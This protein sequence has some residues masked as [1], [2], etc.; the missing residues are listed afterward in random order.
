MNETIAQ[1]AEQLQIIL[2][3]VLEEADRF[4][5]TLPNRPAGI[6]PQPISL[7]PLPPEGLGATGALQAFRRRFAAAMTGSSGSRYF[8]FVTG[9]ATPAAIAGDWLTSIYDQ[10]AFGSEDSAAPYLEQ[11]AIGWLRQLFGLSAAHQGTFVTGA[12]MANLVGLAIGRQWVGHQQGINIAQAGLI[13]LPALTVFSGAPHSC[14]F[15]ALSMLGMGRSSLQ[16]VPCLPDREAIDLAALRQRLSQAAAQQIACIVVANAGT[17]NTGDFDDLQAIAALKQEVPFWLH[18][19]AA[20][21]GFAACSPLY[22]SQVAGLDQADSIAIDAHKWLNVP[23]DAAMQFTRHRSLQIQVFQNSAAYLG[24]DAEVPPE[25]PDFVHLTPENS[26]RLRALPAWFSLLA[27]GAE[28]YRE[29][30]E[31]NC[32]I[33]QSLGNQIDESPD[34]RL[35]APVRLNVVCFTLAAPTPEA[36]KQFLT[37]LNRQGKIFLTPTVYQGIPAIRA[38]FSNWRTEAEDGAIAWEALNQ[39]IE[40]ALDLV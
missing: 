32:A 24:A 1:D 30:V 28:G 38:A 39:A 33:A 29:I 14:I 15:K 21:G 19:D 7:K 20:F 22:R 2:S 17:V 10:N 25:K 16:T 34:F 37:I 26:R 36:I 40:A 23:Y 5:R 9:G 27:Y 18:V 11:E 12:T 8:G 4:F 6:P 3:Q 31:R 13:G 35:L